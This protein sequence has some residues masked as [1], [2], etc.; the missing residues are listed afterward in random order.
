MA[1]RPIRSIESISVV[2]ILATALV[3]TALARPGV[4]ASLVRTGGV[5]L[6]ILLDGSA[7]MHVRD[8]LG[9]RWQ[10]SVVF[11]DEDRGEWFAQRG[12]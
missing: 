1:A 2:L 10:R 3:I 5:D 7:S 11:R 8:V 12:A 4:V 9:D 6:V